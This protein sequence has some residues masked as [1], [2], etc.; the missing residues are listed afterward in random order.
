MKTNLK[1][2]N[3]KLPTKQKSKRVSLGWCALSV[4]GVYLSCSLILIPA[5]DGLR[6]QYNLM[7]VDA[8]LAGSGEHTL[9]MIGSQI[10]FYLASLLSTV[11]FFL[12]AS[13]IVNLAAARQSKRAV[14]A[15][16]ITL[17]GMNCGTL[18]SLIVFLFL[19][20]TNPQLTLA[21]SF[22]EKVLFEGLFYLACVGVMTA[23]TLLLAAKKAPT[24]IC[25]LACTLTM[26]VIGA[27]G[28]EL[29]DN[30]PFFL[31]GTILTEDLITMVLSILIYVLHS[32]VGFFIMMLMTRN[33]KE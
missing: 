11:A 12:G 2:Q 17:A 30:I 18:L 6:E 21:D 20:L 1:Y 15:A 29:F 4:L 10:F 25:A 24:Y 14:G 9:A 19:K 33:P 31:N 3:G 7:S 16:A 5:S 23:A 28:L 22:A 13:Y 32:A 8:A 27:V 26:F